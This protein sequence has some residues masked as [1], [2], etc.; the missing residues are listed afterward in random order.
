MLPVVQWPRARGRLVAAANPAALVV[1]RGRAVGSL[2][3][4]ITEMLRQRSS[5]SRVV[6]VAQVVDSHGAWAT[7]GAL[8]AAVEAWG[9]RAVQVTDS[10]EW[11]GPPRWSGQ[12]QRP[13]PARAL[14]GAVDVRPSDGW[15]SVAP[16]RALPFA[17]QQQVVRVL[18]AEPLVREVAGFIEELRSKGRSVGARF[19]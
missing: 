16:A 18:G 9:S 1:G 7:A 2:V 17:D 12:W 13:R 14:A 6:V 8:A 15:R 4:S 5:P 19:R 11:I 3:Q 10:L